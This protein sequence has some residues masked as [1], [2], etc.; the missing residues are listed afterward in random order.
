[1]L[2]G[3][4]ET[5]KVLRRENRGIKDDPQFSGYMVSYK[6]IV[7][8]DYGHP[9]ELGYTTCRKKSEMEAWLAEKK[10]EAQL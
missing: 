6:Y 1:M 8:Y 7:F 4:K 9:T 3:S 2:K 10:K 5:M